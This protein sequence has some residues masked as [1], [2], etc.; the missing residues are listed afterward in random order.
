MGSA[1][2]FQ[3]MFIKPGMRFLVLGIPQ[4]LLAFMMLFLRE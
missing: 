1:D 3:K 2:L 4:E